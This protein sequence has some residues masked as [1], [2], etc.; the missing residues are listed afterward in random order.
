[1]DKKMEKI[2]NGFQLFMKDTNGVGEAF[3]NAV[4]LEAKESALDEKTQELAYIAV[5][6]ALKM[7]Q[8]LPFHIQHAKECGATKEEIK[9]AMLV[10]MPMMGLQVAEALPFLKEN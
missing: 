2:T 5:L 10:P 4:M 1:M 3:M 9:S 7:Y 6:V 8:G